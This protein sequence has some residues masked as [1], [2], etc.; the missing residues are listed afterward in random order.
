MASS[1]SETVTHVACVAYHPQANTGESVLWTEIHPHRA[2]FQT[3]EEFDA[4]I[5]SMIDA[6]LEI[7]QVMQIGGRQELWFKGH[8]PRTPDVPT[9]D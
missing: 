1:D 9:E 3:R 4:A 7:F 5:I 2:T 6:R 8:A